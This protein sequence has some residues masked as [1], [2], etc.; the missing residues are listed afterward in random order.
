MIR[1]VQTL[2]FVTCARPLV[3]P[4]TGEKICEE[5]YFAVS[6]CAGNGLFVFMLNVGFITLKLSMNTCQSFLLMRHEN[7][8]QN[9]DKSLF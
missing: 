3:L 6:Y 5:S 4:T 2:L 7:A 1:F 9:S 8:Q